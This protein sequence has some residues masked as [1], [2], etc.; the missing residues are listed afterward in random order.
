MDELTLSLKIV[1]ANSFVM[2]FK[3]H[4]HHWNVKGMEFSQ[5]HEFFG[6]IYAELFAAVDTTAEEIRALD[7]EAPKT[8]SE[9]YQFKTVNEGNVSVTAVE[10]LNDLLITN[11]GVIESLNKAMEYAS[12]AN[13]QGLMDFLAGRLDTHKKHAWMIRSHLQ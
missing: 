6:D 3:A 4:S 5:L 1:L 8:L 12:S 7:Q 10:M 2:Y 9:M 11:T 13:D